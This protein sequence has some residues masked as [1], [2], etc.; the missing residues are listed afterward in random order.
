MLLNKQTKTMKIHGGIKGIANN[1]VS[2]DQYFIIA[3]EISSII[4]KFYTFFGITDGDNQ[5]HHY[6]LKGGKNKK[7]SDNVEKLTTVFDYHNTNFEES[8]CV[9]NTVTKKILLE[10]FAKVFLNHE[11]KGEKRLQEFTNDRVKGSISIWKPLKKTKL[12]T[13]NTNAKSFKTNIHGKTIRFKEERN[14]MSRLIVAARSRPEIDISKYFGDYE[15]SVVPRSLFHDDG[16]L[17]PT[18]D[19][20]VILQELEHL[21]PEI[22]LTTLIEENESVIIFDGMAVVNRIDIQKQKGIIKT[23]RYFADV[24]Q[25]LF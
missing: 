8:D 15:F 21:Y 1:Q 14:L 17:V 12:R 19:K 24:F 22:N 16:K 2:L 4:E 20:Y 5:E 11:Q 10:K 7:I 6:Q 3:P 23:C 13:F 9:Y 25:K 18:K